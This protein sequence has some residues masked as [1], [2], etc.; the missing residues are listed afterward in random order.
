MRYGEILLS[1]RNK[2]RLSRRAIAR[3]AGISEGHLRFVEKGE[4]STTP[5]TLRRLATAIGVDE[6]PVLESWLRENMP[7]VDY[8]TLTAQLPDKLNLEELT[9]LYEIEKAKQAFMKAEKITAKNFNSLSLQEFFKIRTGLQNCLKF[10]QE[11][12]DEPKPA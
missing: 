10:I 5:I 3:Q 12:E 8:S 9:R 4:R 1:A 2:A 11:L 6:R 7:S